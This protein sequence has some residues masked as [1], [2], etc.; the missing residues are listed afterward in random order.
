MEGGHPD[1][2]DGHSEQW[3]RTVVDKARDAHAGASH[4]ETDRHEPECP[5]AVAVVADERLDQ[6][7]ADASCQDEGAHRRTAVVTLELMSAQQCPNE[8]THSVERAA[9][10]GGA[11]VFMKVFSAPTECRRHRD[12]PK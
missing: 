2:A 9:G 5:R 4:H 6:C 7:A 10:R 3:K 12:G 8:R 11:R 1:A